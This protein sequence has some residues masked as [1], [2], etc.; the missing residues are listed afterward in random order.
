MELLKEL[1]RLLQAVKVE[2]GERLAVS[3]RISSNDGFAMK[4]DS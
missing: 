4:D 1:Y 2:I 3:W